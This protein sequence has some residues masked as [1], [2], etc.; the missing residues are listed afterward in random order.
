MAC[1]KLC[2]RAPI[3]FLFLYL[4]NVTE[5]ISSDGEM[6]TILFNQFAVKETN[7]S[8]YFIMVISGKL[9]FFNDP[10]MNLK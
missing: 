3:K 9:N 5:T 1:Q 4:Q 10:Y 6:M 7:I 2:H 8:G